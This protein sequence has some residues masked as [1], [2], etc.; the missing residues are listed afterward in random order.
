MRK[1]LKI[2][3]GIGLILIGL[4]GLLLPVMPGWAFII[5]GL[6]ILA[7]YFPAVRR[8]LD[9]AKAKLEGATGRTGGTGSAA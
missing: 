3:A 5:P 7:D 2:A 8:L 1:P 6:I 4:L 9:W